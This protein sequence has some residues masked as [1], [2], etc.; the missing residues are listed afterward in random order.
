MIFHYLASLPWRKP[1]AIIYG[2]ATLGIIL[3][4]FV[5][6]KDIPTN[7]YHLLVV[8]DT[9]IFSW[10]YGTSTTEAIKVG[11]EEVWT[12]EITK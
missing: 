4:C 5:M 1:L 3:A 9:V 11:S 7:A 10:A 6:Q 12:P 8:T 2:I